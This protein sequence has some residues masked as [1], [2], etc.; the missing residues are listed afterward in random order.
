M[1][2]TPV[3]LV[4]VN[5]LSFP[6]APP[7]GLEII[8]SVLANKN[9]TSCIHQPYLFENPER[10]L[11]NALEKA[12]PKVVGISF[13]NYD[14][15]GLHFFEENSIDFLKYLVNCIKIIKKFD[16]IVAIGGSGFSVSPQH[17]LGSANGDVGFIG[18]SEHDFSIFCSKI[19]FEQKSI[20]N[21]IEGLCSAF[22]P[23]QSPPNPT[24]VKLGVSDNLDSRS[25]TFSKIV[26]GRIPVRT[27][28]GCSMNCS[29]CVVPRIEPLILRS[30]CDIRLELKNAIRS[31]GKSRV[32]IADGEFNLP[33][34]ERAIALCE[35]IHNCFGSDIE[36]E[37]Y[38]DGGTV[39]KKL[40]ASLK[41]AGCV[42]VSLTTDSLSKNPRR[43]MNKI[44]GVDKAKISIENC[45]EEGLMTGV[46]LLF[47]GP[48]ETQ[49]SA[50]ESAEI[51]LKYNKLGAFL[52]ISVGLIVYPNTP[53]ALLCK[54]NDQKQFFSIG[55]RPNQLGYFCSP[56]PR[57]ILGSRISELLSPSST[58]NYTETSTIKI[59][60]FYRQL[61]Y[62]SNILHDKCYLDA[63]RQFQKLALQY[64]GKPQPELGYLKAQI[65]LLKNSDD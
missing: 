7:Y 39:T 26:G 23:G 53:L 61:A 42:G 25:L 15:A 3:L 34:N 13:R 36:W 41:T 18:P 28:T 22:L 14:S 8:K 58:I 50:L 32:F 31:K 40:A 49:Q 60:N 48:G 62:A 5:P 12:K 46:N 55:F 10:Y 64:P 51:A 16:C 30:W 29:Y 11:S 19:I 47:G 56:E 37:C 59:R 9:I 1:K 20:E 21:A 35:N 54:L 44:N 6:Y 4:Y 2:N 57:N 65:G 24:I 38:L 17:L 45:L 63:A 27:K 52:M 33:T 43:L